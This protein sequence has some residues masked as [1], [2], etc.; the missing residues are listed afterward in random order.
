MPQ[1]TSKAHAIEQLKKIYHY[2]HLVVFGDGENDIDMFQLAD[3]S[4]AVDNAHEK[5]KAI[6]T[7][8]IQSNNEDG[9]AHFLKQTFKKL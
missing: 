4:Y 6:A 8:V 1:N 3:E 9:V 7:Q 5:L 2:D